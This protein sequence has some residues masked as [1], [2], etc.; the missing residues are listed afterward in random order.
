MSAL[1]LHHYPTSPF[2]EKIRLVLGFKKLDWQG[3][4][5]PMVM[6]K[7]DLMPLTG[8]YRRKS[9]QIFIATPA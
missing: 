9:A 4:T 5:I 7:P 3:V 6:P 2:A 1:I 8:G